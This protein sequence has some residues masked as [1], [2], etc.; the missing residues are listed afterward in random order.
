MDLTIEP[1]E[2]AFSAKNMET[3]PIAIKAIKTK[4]I[5]QSIRESSRQ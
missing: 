5:R 3:K 2:S 1:L 4:M